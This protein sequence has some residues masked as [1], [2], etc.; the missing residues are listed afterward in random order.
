LD[1]LY[2]LV[3]FKMENKMEDD[4]KMYAAF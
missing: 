4:Y 1:S 3:R 2:A